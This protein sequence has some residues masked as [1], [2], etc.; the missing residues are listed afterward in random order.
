MSTHLRRPRRT[1]L[2]ALTIIAVL[3]GGCVSMSPQTS[4]RTGQDA[5]HPL[6]AQA[7]EL[8]RAGAGNQQIDALLAQLDDDTLAGQA[9]ALAVGDPLY[10]HLARAL[11]SRGLALPRPL[12]RAR[13]QFDAGSRPP[14]D[15]RDGYR[16]PVKLGVLLPLSGGISAA[17]APVRD[18]FL[19]GYY[20][21]SRRRPEVAFY[22]THGTAGGAVAAYDQAVA[23][24]ND[25]VVGPLSRT[26]VDALFRRGAL[27]VPVLALNHGQVAPPAGNASFS[28]SPEDEGIAAADL[29]VKRGAKRVLVVA[30]SDDQARRSVAALRERLTG[31]GVVVTD[32]LSAGVADLTPFVQKEGGVDAI[33]L[34]LRGSA[35]RELMPRLAMA[36]LAG[37][38]MVATSQ[39]I[40]DTGEVDE[41]RILDGIA[42]PGGTWTSGG[43][44]PGLPSAA[45]AAQTVS[46]ARGGAA[47]LF[48]FGYDAWL[49]TAYLDRL[50]QSAD[51]YVA[52]ATGALS[53][54]ASGNVQRV[55]AW[56]TFSGGVVVPLGNG[57]RY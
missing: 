35:A 51:A 23:A 31:Q 38:P 43:H 5:M 30:D 27:P 34:A 57:N 54:D 33:F 13:W 39:L 55:P 46:T 28:L 49:L 10:N 7:G 20:A 19:A 14:A 29:L 41:D 4:T 48:A 12:E 21:E 22:D 45:S 47:R 44:V 52:G 6:V 24:G 2:F 50:S 9:A 16:P 40:S 3:L 25:F 36:G 18:G 53:I 11:L 56:L 8:L 37:K 42:F 32:V 26:G 15:A 1:W 17:A